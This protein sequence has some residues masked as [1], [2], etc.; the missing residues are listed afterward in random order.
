MFAD[1]QELTCKLCGKPLIPVKPGQR[2]ILCCPYDPGVRTKE[3]SKPVIKR[4]LRK[5]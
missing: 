5:K 4:L 1:G 2:Q 3:K